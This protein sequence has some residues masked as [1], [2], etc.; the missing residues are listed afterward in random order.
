MTMQSAFCWI[1]KN[2]NRG[3]AIGYNYDHNGGNAL[4]SCGGFMWTAANTCAMP[5]TQRWTRASADNR[6]LWMSTGCK[7]TVLGAS[8]TKMNHR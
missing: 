4:G 5:P 2:P 7:E 6:A 1:S 8:A 3:V